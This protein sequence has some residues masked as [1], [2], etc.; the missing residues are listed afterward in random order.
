MASR[1]YE[2]LRKDV[3]SDIET[4]PWSYVFLALTHLYMLAASL[5]PCNARSSVAWILTLKL[6][7]Y[8]PLGWLTNVNI[9]ISRCHVNSLAPGRFGMLQIKVM[10][11]F[12]EIAFRWMPQNTFDEKSTL[13][14][15]MAWYSLATSHYLS[16]CWLRFM[17][18][19][20]I[21]RPKQVKHTSKFFR[22]IYSKPT[23]Q[24]VSVSS[25]DVLCLLG[26]PIAFFTNFFLFWCLYSL[27]EFL[28]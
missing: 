7:G 4:G 22:F 1:L 10:C 25:D 19:Y 28:F 23:Q 8:C 5:A 16:Q 26:A 20:D 14:E 12:C 2:I 3:F 15:E 24:K 27:S 18:E 13:V 9:L 11:T 17:S 21:S 6:A